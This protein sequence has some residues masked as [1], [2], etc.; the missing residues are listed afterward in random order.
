MD[1][2]GSSIFTAGS[3][4]GSLMDAIVSPTDT[5]SIPVIMIMSPAIASFASTGVSPLYFM[6]FVTLFEVVVPSR[7]TRATGS[8][9]RTAP[10]NMRPIA[11][12]PKYEL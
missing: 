2:V 8:P 12:R 3:A 7:F 6:I 11:I 5:P 4:F 10:W 1:T 9:T